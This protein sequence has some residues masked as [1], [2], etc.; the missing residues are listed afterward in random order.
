M[1]IIRNKTE[2]YH[3][4]Q[5][6]RIVAIDDTQLFL[7]IDEMLNSTYETSNHNLFYGDGKASSRIL[8][9]IKKEYVK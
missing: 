9:W 6:N 3:Q 4:S 5:L 1:I 8:E 7:V 2:R